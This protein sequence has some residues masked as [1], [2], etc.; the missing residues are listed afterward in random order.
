MPIAIS[1]RLIF[2]NE[3]H[4]LTASKAISNE[5]EFLFLA[6]NSIISQ[7]SSGFNSKLHP[8]CLLYQNIQLLYY[9]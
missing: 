9:A 1:L 8:N 5:E 4:M 2:N 6:Y 7:C 3:A